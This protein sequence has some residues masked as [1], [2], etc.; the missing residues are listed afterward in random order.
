MGL[1]P[2]DARRALPLY[3]TPIYAPLC[4]ALL[5]LIVNNLAPPPPHLHFEKRSQGLRNM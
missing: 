2:L 5:Y 3:P 1:C 4:F